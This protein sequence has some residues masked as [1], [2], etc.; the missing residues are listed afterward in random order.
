MATYPEAAHKLV[1]SC[2]SYLGGVASL[3]QTKS[4]IW[5]AAQQ[6]VLV[7]EREL[8]DFLQAAEGR[9]D[10]IEHT[11]DAP[12]VF[13]ATSLVVREVRVRMLTYLA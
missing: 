5:D 4:A 6:I 8:R 2:D 3:A 10:L 7:D 1:A 11:T 12:S 13:Q 9:L